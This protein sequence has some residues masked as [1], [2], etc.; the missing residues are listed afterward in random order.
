MAAQL[1][2]SLEELQASYAAVTIGGVKTAE[3]ATQIRGVMTGMVKPTT[4]MKEAF[5]KLGYAS[6]EQAIAAL[7]FVGTMNAVISTTDGSTTSIA[8]SFRECVDST[9]CCV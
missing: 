6:A 7:G 4:A 8:N 3:A 9:P 2:I 1:G 5:Q